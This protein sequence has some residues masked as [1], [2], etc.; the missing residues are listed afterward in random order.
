MCGVKGFT[1]KLMYHTQNKSAA[2]AS[3]DMVKD[4]MADNFKR[5]SIA[6]RAERLFLCLKHRFPGL[7]QTSL[8]ISKIQHNKVVFSSCI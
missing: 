5:D 7:S 3:L 1:P 2:K 8:D 4:L 6:D